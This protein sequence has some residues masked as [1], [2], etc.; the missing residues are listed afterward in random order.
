MPISEM[1]GENGRIIVLI[2]FIALLICIPVIRRFSGAKA[3]TTQAQTGFSASSKPYGVNKAS[4]VTA[5][6]VAAVTEYRKYNS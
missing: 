6:I 5:A 1:L 2:G 4:A 3:E